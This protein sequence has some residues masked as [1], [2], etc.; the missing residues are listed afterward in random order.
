M[1]KIVGE[2]GSIEVRVGKLKKK[3][4]KKERWGQVN[5]EK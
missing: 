3:K 4:M 1:E 2:T 5:I